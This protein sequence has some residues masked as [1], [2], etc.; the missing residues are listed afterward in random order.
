MGSKSL[1]LSSVHGQ[2]VG[3]AS[4]G[5]SCA[6]KYD[7][8][9]LSLHQSEQAAREQLDHDATLHCPLDMPSRVEDS[10]TANEISHPPRGSYDLHRTRGEIVNYRYCNCDTC[11]VTRLGEYTTSH[12][13]GRSEI[14]GPG[15]G[16]SGQ[17]HLSSCSYG[18]CH[19]KD[20]A[21]VS[22]TSKQARC[23]IATAL[24]PIR[25]YRT[26]RIP[27]FGHG[28]HGA[29]GAHR[30]ICQAR[31]C[32]KNFSANQ[33]SSSQNRHY[34]DDRYLP[35]K[36]DFLDGHFSEIDAEM[37]R[38]YMRR[39]HSP[40]NH[41]GHSWKDATLNIPVHTSHGRSC[42]RDEEERS[43]PKRQVNEFRSLHHEQL[44]LAPNEKFHECLD[45]HR[46]FRNAYNGK[47][48]KRKF[49]KQGFHESTYNGAGASKYERNSSQKRKAGHLGGKKA[50]NNVAYEDK[51][52]RLRWPSEKD[53]KQQVETDK[54]RNGS[55]E[56]NAVITKFVGR[57]GGKGNCNPKQDATAAA[58]IGSTKCDENANML[59][60]KCSKTVAS[61]NTPKLSEGSSDM[62][63]ESD[64]QSDV[65]GCT[66]RGIL[67]HLPVTHTERNMELKESDN[68]SQSE[69]LHQDCL[70][71]WRARQLRKAN[72]AK[73][74]KIVK[75][76][77]RQAGQR[78]KVSTGRRVSNGRPAAFATS[79]SDNEDDSALGCSDQFSSATSSDG[80]QKCGDGRANKKLERPL[81]FPSNSKCNKIPQNATAEKGL[82]CSLKLPPEA[83]P[84]ELAQQKEKEKIL[85]RRQLS[86]YHPDAI[87]H[88][89]L[90]G[91]SDTSM[92]DEAAVSHCD[93]RA[94]QNI[95]HQETNN[96]DR[97][98]EKLGVK[99]EKRAEGHG[100]KWAQQSTSLYTEPTLLDQETI[101][102]CSMHGNLKVN[103]LET[104]N[105][106]SGSTPFHGHILDGRTANM[107]Q[108]KQVNRS[109]GSYC[110][111]FKN[112]LDGNDH[113][114]NQQE[115]MDRNLLRK[116]QVC[117]VLAGPENELNENDTKDCEPQALG[118]ENTSNRQ[119]TTEDCTSNT[120]HSGA[121][122]QGDW[123]P[124]SCIPDLN[125][126][127]SMLSDEDFVAPEE[128]VC[129]VTAGGFEPQDVTKSLSAL[130]TGPIVKEQQYEQAKEQQCRQPEATQ[131]I[132]DVCK[133]EGTSEVV[134][135]L[136]ISESNNG[137]PQRSAVEESSVP[138]DAFM[139]ALYEFVKNFL[140]PLWENGLVSREVHKIV[141]K[142]AVEKVAGA[143]ASNAPSTEPA[144][145]RILSDE[146]KNI[147]RLV[148]GYLNMYV[149]R[150]VLKSCPWWCLS[151][152]AK[153]NAS[154][155]MRSGG[156][157]ACDAAAKRPWSMEGKNN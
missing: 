16:V 95:S 61:L 153:R 129:Q 139:C 99:C 91:C 38:F 18:G 104:P 28:H 154:R 90:N 112:W 111:D 30:Q 148:Q 23:S 157:E 113:I 123:I 122:K 150:E 106:E 65:D 31:S 46:Y 84:L 35:S 51:S 134:A 4:G 64:K 73:A 78:R 41:K 83:N 69:A 149:G 2:T 24:D 147:E 56:G 47:M 94:H 132:S 15:N 103:A 79:E 67:Q 124:R 126:S 89:G 109:S 140:K 19:G 97:R 101:A 107:C 144:I 34:R 141:V 88:G 86:T 60:P 27:S 36:H 121:A 81:K 20:H 116:K 48:V 57:D 42:Q 58:A 62:D 85:N 136:E 98:K 22:N 37:H 80:L 137:L 118:V 151:G 63:L 8:Q 53:Q 6:E 100:L 114:D 54:R 75:A 115:A 72:A 50:R 102:R 70:I 74:D 125:Y 7:W 92:V 71:L 17:C 145:S 156:C 39:F 33:G 133:K 96:A 29:K 13:H 105:H 135:Q 5:Y 52:K 110:R 49:I 59:S 146:A 152:P 3:Q 40:S 1:L 142:K 138:T 25:S 82:E 10:V 12:G 14:H 87:V 44:E 120:T 119:I 108:K 127:P 11:G 32:R 68:L 9:N 21:C 76:N 66:E 155:S 55:L 128:P 77:Q 130:L 117:S 26:N 43:H 131:I 93:N 143:W 45:S